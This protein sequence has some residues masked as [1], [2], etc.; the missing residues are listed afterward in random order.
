MPD[1]AT[2]DAWLT[3]ARLATDG[4]SLTAGFDTTESSHWKR[5]TVQR[6]KVVYWFMDQMG[7]GLLEPSLTANAMRAQTI[8]ERIF[9]EATTRAESA[10]AYSLANPE[11]AATN[12][13]WPSFSGSWV[14][15]L[16]SGLFSSATANFDEVEQRAGNFATLVGVP[17][18]SVLTYGLAGRSGP[19][20]KWTS[21]LQFD[22]T[23]NAWHTK[24]EWRGHAQR[25]RI[26]QMSPASFN[27][28][29]R[30]LASYLKLARKLIPGLWRDG[31]DAQ[32]MT[33]FE[34]NYEADI[35]GYDKSV[36]AWL[37]VAIAE[38]WKRVWPHL[39]AE[40]DFWISCERRGLITPDW[41]LDSNHCAV[42]S[43]LGGT[44][45]GLKLTSEI[46]TWAGLWATLTALLDQ[47]VDISTWPA[48]P[49]FTSL[50]QGDDVRI[51]SHKQLDPDQWA[52]S[53]LTFNLKCDLVLGDG[54]LAKHTINGLAT[55]I[56]GRLVQ[57]TMSNEHEPRG[58]SSLGISY[59]GFL[60]RV[61]G[62]EALPPRYQ[63]AI[64]S[65]I[66][67]AKWIRDTGVGGIAPL[68]K[69]LQ[70]PIAQEEIRTA[71]LTKQGQSWLEEEARTPDRNVTAQAIL[72]LAQK[73]GVPVSAVSS[74]DRDV[75]ALIRSS[76]TLPEPEK[77]QL[78]SEGWAA[79]NSGPTA[80]VNWARRLTQRIN[81]HLNLP[82]ETN[83]LTPA[84]EDTYEH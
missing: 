50:Q 15:K 48:S 3:A 35:S 36:P 57:Q 81:L 21:M 49:V 38:S 60:A 25:N 40:I 80:G 23:K 34:F 8:M 65:V 77:L 12:P 28:S 42:V 46:G 75:D 78:A 69:F 64:W 59:I 39:T 71:L 63:Q 5:L 70:G 67:H 45:T 20:Y 43:S 4:L 37:Q 47:G 16:L 29:L 54:F 7:P 33:G 26:V 79:L 44:R 41:E 62:W 72:A 14:G 84:E 17:Q 55:P 24:A 82:D 61:Q 13:G 76:L 2:C 9:A 52:A 27:F 11:P 31:L 32:R 58:R 10:E 68:V 56:A 73:L 53:F 30:R 6:G 83:E 74:L 66:R 22:T 51:G 19:V 18:A 1:D